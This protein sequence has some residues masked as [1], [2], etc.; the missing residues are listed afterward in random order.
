MEL[1]NVILNF[2]WKNKQAIVAKNTLKMKNNEK[3]LTILE[4]IFY[5][6]PIIKA[7]S[8]MMLWE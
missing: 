7:S 3:S 5:E 6:P 2:M 8:V 1:D 4:K